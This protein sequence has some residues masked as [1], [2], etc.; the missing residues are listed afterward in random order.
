MLRN[1]ETY[2]LQE[3]AK[4]KNYLF[5]KNFLDKSLE[6]L[7]EHSRDKDS[8]LLKG[9]S[10]NYISVLMDETDDLKGKLVKVKIKQVETNFTVGEAENL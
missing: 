4:E 5:R 1:P 10:D 9:L 3:L 2:K 7:I 6:I 8:G